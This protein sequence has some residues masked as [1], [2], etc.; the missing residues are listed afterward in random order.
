MRA[1]SA[2]C[3]IALTSLGSGCAQF[4]QG[5]RSDEYEQGFQAGYAACA[6]EQ[7]H[8]RPVVPADRD[9][10]IA[11]AP[12]LAPPYV[13]EPA[14]ARI[15]G[16]REVLAAPIEITNAVPAQA[17]PIHIINGPPPSGRARILGVRQAIEEAQR[18]R[19]K[20][21]TTAP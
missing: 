16:L 17:E 19:I 8:H 12:Y 4:A 3:C 10:K 11:N 20:S 1:L 13:D 6:Q 2:L 5:P 14:K 15:L 9:L 21:I 7:R 18:A